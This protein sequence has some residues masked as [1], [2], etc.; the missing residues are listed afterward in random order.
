MLPDDPSPTVLI[1]D[2]GEDV[3]PAGGELIVFTRVEPEHWSITSLWLATPG[4]APRRLGGTNVAEFT[5]DIACRMVEYADMD[6][7]M[8]EWHHVGLEGR[9]SWYGRSACRKFSHGFGGDDENNSDF[10]RVMMQFQQLV[11]QA[12]HWWALREGYADQVELEQGVSAVLVHHA[13]SPEHEPSQAN[14]SDICLLA[15]GRTDLDIPRRTVPLNFVDKMLAL[16]QQ[17]AAAGL[18]VSDVH[19][20]AGGRPTLVVRADKVPEALSQ[21][22]GLD[23]LHRQLL[24]ISADPYMGLSVTWPGHHLIARWNNVQQRFLH[25]FQRGEFLLSVRE[26]LPLQWIAPRDGKWQE[27]FD[28]ECR[29]SV[30]NT[31]TKRLKLI[32]NWQDLQDERPSRDMQTLEIA[33]GQTVVWGHNDACQPADTR[34]FSVERDPVPF[35]DAASANDAEEWPKMVARI[36]KTLGLQHKDAPYDEPCSGGLDQDEFHDVSHWQAPP[37]FGGLNAKEKTKLAKSLMREVMAHLKRPGCRGGYCRA[38]TW[39]CPQLKLFETK[40]HYWT[41]DEMGLDDSASEEFGNW[42]KTAGRE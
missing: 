12:Q 29:G 15:P 37:G 14:E 7:A 26:E 4:K 11:L 18:L 24:K 8:H 42:P 28:G 10:A 31:S 41:I 32:V 17:V 3:Q 16:R 5:V 38:C 20:E 21:W 1:R 25:Q 6:G 23:A 2:I 35:W 39:T 13:T 34:F 22:P 40:D 33:P 30:R 19:F 36:A 27:E 9:P